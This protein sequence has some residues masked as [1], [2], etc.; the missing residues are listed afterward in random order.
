M[1]RVRYHS[2]LVDKFID[3]GGELGLKTN[4]EYTVDPEYGSYRLQVTTIN[5]RRVNIFI[6]LNAYLAT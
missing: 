5:E 3:S 6:I 1:E 2:P 4:I